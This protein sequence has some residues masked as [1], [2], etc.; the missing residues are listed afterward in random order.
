MGKMK[1]QL[2]EAKIPY[3]IGIARYEEMAKGSWA[4]ALDY[5]KYFSIPERYEC[6]GVHVIGENAAEIVYIG[7]AVLSLGSTIEYFATQCL[8]IGPL[9]RLHILIALCYKGTCE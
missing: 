9:F 2:T 3:E 8:L 1:A 4:M 6:W 7:Q 5:R